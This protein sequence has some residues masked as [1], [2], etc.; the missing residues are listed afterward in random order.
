VILHDADLAGLT[1]VEMITHPGVYIGQWSTR[2]PDGRRFGYVG[3]STNLMQRV[4]TNKMLRDFDKPLGLESLILMIGDGMPLTPPDAT[5]LERIVHRSVDAFGFVHLLSSVPTG[6]AVGLSRYRA[7]RGFW[8][9]AAGLLNKQGILFTRPEDLAAVS[10]NGELVPAGGRQHGGRLVIHEGMGVR[11]VVRICKDGY[12]VLAGSEIR[13][14]VVLSTSELPAVMREEALYCGVLRT[15]S[16]SGVLVLMHDIAFRTATAASI[17][18]L[19][20]RGAGPNSWRDVSEA[21]AMSM[22]SEHFDG[23]DTSR[24][25]RESE[26]HRSVSRTLGDSCRQ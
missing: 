22:L 4:R 1:S 8:L 21:L 23:I 9:E 19:G 3:K 13:S 20:C 12:V 17:F 15:S 26:G 5:A 6:H 25:I 18:V 14:D 24:C 2:A 16:R 10:G 11:A 7:L